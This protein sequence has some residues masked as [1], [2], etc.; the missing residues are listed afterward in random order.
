MRIAWALSAALFV[1]AG[2]ASVGPATVPRARFDY[3][4]A[5][6][7]SPREIAIQSRSMMQVLADFGSYV[8]V[9]QS[10]IDEGRVYAAERDAQTAQEFPALLRVRYS[11][12]QPAATETGSAPSAPVVTVPAR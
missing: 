10:D 2:C 8:D 6:S 1:L 5:I 7:E 12:R 3:V 4:E 9:P 11:V